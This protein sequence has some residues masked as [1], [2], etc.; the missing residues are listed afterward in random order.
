MVTRIGFYTGK[1]YDSSVDTSTIKECC[2]ILNND[3]LVKD[4]EFLTKKRF[5]LKVNCNGCH[6][7]EESRK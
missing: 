5:E 3:E 4:E 6:G 7:C 1:I 2:Q